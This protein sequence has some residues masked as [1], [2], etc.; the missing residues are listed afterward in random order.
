MNLAS[1]TIAILASVLIPAVQGQD[2]GAGAQQQNAS[3][4][5]EQPVPI[6][7]G[8]FGLEGRSLEVWRTIA[9]EAKSLPDHAWA[10]RYYTGDGLGMNVSLMVAPQSG[11]LWYWTGCLGMYGLN[12]GGVSVNDRGQLVLQPVKTGAEQGMGVGSVYWPVQWGDHR[13]L[14]EEG[15]EQQF[16]DLILSGRR[17]L[18]MLP[19]GV[20]H[21]ERDDASAPRG[22]PVVPEEMARMLTPEPIEAH[23]VG[24]RISQQ[25]DTL[26]R[27]RRTYVTL[28]KG[29]ADGVR[30]DGWLVGN[31]SVFFPASGTAFERLKISDVEEH[32]SHGWL[33]Q[34]L[35][36]DKHRPPPFIGQAVTS[37]W[38]TPS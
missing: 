4:L 37:G 15:A 1:L 17:G 25:L 20:F 7:R 21:G 11:F 13:F 6:P 29:R 16:A 36:S 31:A 33:E 23:I 24:V 18:E 22:A 2:E 27:V 3:E 14:V 10:G 30:A 35:E 19:P 5:H 26:P 8:S 12:H 9:A 38:R 34:V 28:D 32:L